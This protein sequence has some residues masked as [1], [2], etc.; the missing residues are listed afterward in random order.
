S[1]THILTP[2]FQ[3]SPTYGSPIFIKKHE[4]NEAPGNFNGDAR[5][6]ATAEDFYTVATQGISGEFKPYRQEDG[7]YIT[8]LDFFTNFDA[9]KCQG[10]VDAIFDYLDVAKCEE[11]VQ[12]NRTQNL[13]KSR[14]YLN[15][16]GT[17][18]QS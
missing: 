18:N 2:M 17:N 6:M 1:G 16:L 12:I 13:E 10:I 8:S 3:F 4:V 5:L 15:S 9:V 14:N 11:L 7:D